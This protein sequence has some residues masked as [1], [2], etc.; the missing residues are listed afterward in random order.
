[1]PRWEGRVTLKGW[2]EDGLLCGFEGCLWESACQ[3]LWMRF[4]GPSLW[5]HM[6]F[7]LLTTNT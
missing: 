2:K 1:M 5:P 7:I 3:G 4:W 6:N